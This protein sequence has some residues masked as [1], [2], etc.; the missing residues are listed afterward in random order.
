MHKISQLQNETALGFTGVGKRAWKLK[1]LLSPQ[2]PVRGV[3]SNWQD[4]VRRE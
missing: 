4:L 2:I 3:L 1:N